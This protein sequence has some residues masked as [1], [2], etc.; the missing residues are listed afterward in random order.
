LVV[1]Y[2]EKPDNLYPTGLQLSLDTMDANKEHI[3]LC[4]DDD[5]D[6]LHLLQIALKEVG[7]NHK[8]VE[9][10]NGEEALIM[11]KEMKHN[12]NLPCLVVLDINMPKIDGKQTLVSIQKDEEMKSMPVVVFTT[13]SN[14]LDQLF[15][16]KKNVEFITKPIQYNTMF[17]V[18]NRLL[19]F[20]KV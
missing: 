20:C 5:P 19:S 17:E 8:I 15:F 11:L 4:V 7:S 12:G 9:A 13:S 3:I 18:A 6:D 1:E 14:P 2:F 16:A 10:Y